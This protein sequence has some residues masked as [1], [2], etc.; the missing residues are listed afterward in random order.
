[1]FRAG[2]RLRRTI[3]HVSIT[4]TELDDG[5]ESWQRC[6]DIYLRSWPTTSSGIYSP[7]EIEAR[8]EQVS[9][10]SFWAHHIGASHRRLLGSVSK[11]GELYHGFSAAE[12]TADGWEYG[13]LF[14]EPEAFGSGLA[15]ALYD[16]TVEG[17]VGKWFSYVLDGNPMSPR[18]LA[19]RGWIPVAAA[20]PEWAVALG[21]RYT[22][23]ERY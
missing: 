2:P 12:L 7:A 10:L 16:A 22:R 21:H 9:E 3:T 18:F 8:L 5:P 15:A 17:A 14:L 23:W 6:C 1:M 11:D 20:Q 19:R 13:W 4:I